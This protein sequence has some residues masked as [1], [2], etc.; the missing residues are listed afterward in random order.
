MSFASAFLNR[1]ES[2][3]ISDAISG[4]V[5]ALLNAISPDAKIPDGLEQA[6]ASNLS[7]GITMTWARGEAG[8]ED[9]IRLSFVERLRIFEPRLLRISSV[10]VRENP[11][12]NEVVFH[13]QAHT[14]DR[15][16]EESV[17][18]EGRLSLFEQMLGQE[19]S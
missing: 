18:L 7:H 6:K 8:R 14:R 11:E 3:D 12:S 13:V 5:D 19:A 2:E 1:P 17:S 9:M 10:E 4:N 16:K 15:E